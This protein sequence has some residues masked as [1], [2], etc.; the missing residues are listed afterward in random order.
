MRDVKN[1]EIL[2]A[3]RSEKTG[4]GECAPLINGKVELASAV[5][6]EAEVLNKPQSSLPVSL[7]ATLMSL[8]L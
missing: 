6:E 2:Q 7:P 5:M 4:K 8:T 1:N 3:H